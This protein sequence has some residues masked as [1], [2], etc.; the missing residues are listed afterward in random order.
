[1]WIKNNEF[2]RDWVRIPP[3]S[4]STLLHFF[5]EIFF[6]LTSLIFSHYKLKP[7]N[8]QSSE[9]T[10]KNSKLIPRTTKNQNEHLQPKF[11]KLIKKY[12][13]NTS[14]NSNVEID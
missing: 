12:Y 14:K 5:H 11:N 13:K 2:S 4:D 6:L 1:V 10:F 8:H 7:Q 9:D 3:K